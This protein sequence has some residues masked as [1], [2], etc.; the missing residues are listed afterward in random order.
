MPNGRLAESRQEG[1]EPVKILES[2]LA[3]ETVPLIAADN[4][5]ATPF[6]NRPYQPYRSYRPRNPSSD[7]MPWKAHQAKSLQPQG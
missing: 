7:G 6:H 5:P 2:R 4:I 1:S 3:R